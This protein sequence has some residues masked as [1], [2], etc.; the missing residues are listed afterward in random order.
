[1]NARGDDERKALR[2]ALSER[3]TRERGHLLPALHHVQHEFG[4]LPDW[5][6]ETVSRHLRVPK[7]EVYG[8]ATSY[9]ELTLDRPGRHALKVCTGLSCS[10]RGAGELL[11]RVNEALDATPIA[12]DTTVAEIA[13]GFLCGV[14]PAVQW[15][16]R[17][18]GR[19][20]AESVRRLIAATESE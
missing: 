16:G 11:D 4:Y 5:A 13:C 9:S 18:I 14:A 12:G 3:Y 20:T 2:R 10:I 17:W 7:S 15:D 6:M 8:A 19:A 1:V